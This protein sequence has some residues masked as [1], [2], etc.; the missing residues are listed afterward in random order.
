[1]D[2][3][4]K[5]LKEIIVEVAKFHPSNMEDN[6]KAWAKEVVDI[7]AEELRELAKME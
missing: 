1:M 7:Y 4:K 3:F 2:K 6:G 5:K